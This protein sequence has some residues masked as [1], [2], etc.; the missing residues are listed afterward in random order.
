MPDYV[1]LLME[2]Q[3]QKLHV[4]PV[5]RLKNGPPEEI[6]L[7][8]KETAPNA[9]E[10]PDTRETCPQIFF[11]NVS[12][13]RRQFPGYLIRVRESIFHVTNFKHDLLL[14]NFWNGAYYLSCWID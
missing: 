7:E 11:A 3:H 9:Y 2:A 14:Q 5:E 10:I 8:N 12:R 13:S 6:A 1:K 4:E